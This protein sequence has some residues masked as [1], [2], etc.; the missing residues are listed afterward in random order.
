MTDSKP[1]FEWNSDL[2]ERRHSRF[3]KMQMGLI[4]LAIGLLMMDLA[5]IYLLLPL[6]LGFLWISSEQRKLDTL[7][8]EFEDAAITLSPRSILIEQPRLDEELR[9]PFHEIRDCAVKRKGYLTTLVLT[10]KEGD[11]VELPGFE[12]I[13]ACCDAINDAIKTAETPAKPA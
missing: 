3:G 5:K 12:E 10:R 7:I 9:I 13:Q 11:P 4:G 6:A 2:F 8:A 1:R